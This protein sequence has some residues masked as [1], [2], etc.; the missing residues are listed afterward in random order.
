M[1][2]ALRQALSQLLITEAPEDNNNRQFRFLAAQIPMAFHL[3]TMLRRE[4]E[5]RL[6]YQTS[7]TKDVKEMVIETML[8]M[9]QS[10]QTLL[11]PMKTID[12][13]HQV[14]YRLRMGK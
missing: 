13:L 3:R 7:S 2:I 12:T 11:S 4:H 10:D 8:H 5:A 6:T 14:T 1:T 9:S